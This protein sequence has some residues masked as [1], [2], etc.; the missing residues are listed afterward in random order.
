MEILLDIEQFFRY[1]YIHEDFSPILS[2]LCTTCWLNAPAL[3]VDPRNVRLDI[4]RGREAR[5]IITA[6]LLIKSLYNRPKY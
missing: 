4:Y 3:L 6:A 1:H 2:S 5:V